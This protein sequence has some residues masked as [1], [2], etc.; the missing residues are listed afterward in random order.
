MVWRENEILNIPTDNYVAEAQGWERRIAGANCFRFFSEAPVLAVMPRRSPGHPISFR[1][2]N[3]SPGR[4]VRAPG[5]DE[6][7]MM[8]PSHSMPPRLRVLGCRLEPACPLPPRQNR[9]TPQNNYLAGAGHPPGGGTRKN[10]Q[11]AKTILGGLSRQLR[12]LPGIGAPAGPAGAGRGA[13][14]LFFGA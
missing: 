12:D 9:P 4:A 14:T 1:G 10:R 7:G 13:E 6:G 8:H 3:G 2:T 11:N 5:D